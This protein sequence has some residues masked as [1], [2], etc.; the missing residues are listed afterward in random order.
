M[1]DLSKL[2]TPLHPDLRKELEAHAILKEVP[3]GTEILREGQY[4]KV[5]PIVLEG[6]I[7]VFSR[8]EEKELLLNK[9][10]ALFITMNP[11]YTGRTEL[12]DNIKNLFRP[13]SMMIPDS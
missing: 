12:P 4:V 1:T 6:L 10:C 9:N 8:H 5:I 13:V 3:Q 2:L 7:K 11:T